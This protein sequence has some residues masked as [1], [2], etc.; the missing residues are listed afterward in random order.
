MKASTLS[1]LLDAFPDAPVT[2][3]DADIMVEVT[4][5]ETGNP[6]FNIQK[7]TAERTL[8]DGQM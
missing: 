2:V 6:I 5:D 3:G 8:K 4:V 7:K 1:D